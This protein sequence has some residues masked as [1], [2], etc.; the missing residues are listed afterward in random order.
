MMALEI[1]DFT[2]R[3]SL[4]LEGLYFIFEY[5]FIILQIEKYEYKT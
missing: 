1:P 4:T 3:P 2:G 5:Y